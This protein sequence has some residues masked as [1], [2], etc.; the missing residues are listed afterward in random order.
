MARRLASSTPRYGYRQCVLPVKVEQAVVMFDARRQPVS[1]DVE[2]VP[3]ARTTGA[4]L[5]GHAVIS[6]WGCLV[7]RTLT[8]WRR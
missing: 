1:Q 3:V 8:C 2:I 4:H 7:S 6:H 5:P